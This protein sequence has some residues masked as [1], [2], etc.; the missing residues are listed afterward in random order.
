MDEVVTRLENCFRVVF[1]QLPAA[2]ILAAS[3]HS[4]AAWDSLAAITLVSVIEEEFGIEMDL[5]AI[6]EFDSFPRI[7][8]YVHGK[9]NA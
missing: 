9:M 2:E 7:R 8:N 5:D 6:A 1:P 3:Q 4:V